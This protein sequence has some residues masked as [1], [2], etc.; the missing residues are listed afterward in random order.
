[1]A[2]KF[3]KITKSDA[4][5]KGSVTLLAA[6]APPA[7]AGNALLVE[8]EFTPYYNAEGGGATGHILKPPYDPRQLERMCSENNA[9]GPC[10]EAMVVNVDG[11]GFEIERI[12][13][14]HPLPLR[15]RP[16]PYRFARFRTQCRPR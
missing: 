4:P 13:M 1:M 8:D 5:A 12:D 9:L 3:T 11:T 14:D 6:A 7:V 2:V 16:G 10:I 15:H